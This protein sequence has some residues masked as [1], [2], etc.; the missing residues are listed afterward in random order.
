MHV[1]KHGQRY[2]AGTVAGYNSGA[3]GSAAAAGLVMGFVRSKLLG[4]RRE[5]YTRARARASAT[6][7]ASR[8][9][10]SAAVYGGG[11]II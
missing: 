3:K 7:N 10:R 11:R 1:H 4:F 8:S 2:S 9:V 5:L 6:C